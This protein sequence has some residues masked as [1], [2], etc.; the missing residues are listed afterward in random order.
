[1]A[2]S[3]K[4]HVYWSENRMNHSQV[5]F[6]HTSKMGVIDPSHKITSKICWINKIKLNKS[7]KKIIIKNWSRTF[8]TTCNA[9]SEQGPRNGPL[10][11]SVV[12]SN[13]G[14]GWNTWAEGQTCSYDWASILQKNFYLRRW[15][16]VLTK[17]FHQNFSWKSN[18]FEHFHLKNESFNKKF[19]RL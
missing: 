16:F 12:G 11:C 18:I 6:F 9:I 4:K 2:L 10:P 7:Y 17:R 8:W 15:F 3:Q 1:M 5:N 13:F 14:R 19:S